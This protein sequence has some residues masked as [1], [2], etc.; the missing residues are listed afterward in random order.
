MDTLDK[1]GRS[2]GKEKWTIEL[3]LEDFEKQNWEI[4]YRTKD[5]IFKLKHNFYLLYAFDLIIC[6]LLIGKTKFSKIFKLLHQNM[7]RTVSCGIL[8]RNMGFFKLLV[9][10]NFK[11]SLYIFG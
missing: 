2:E 8:E 7:N 10:K 6:H 3:F 9:G 4:N 1:S 11:G 5:N